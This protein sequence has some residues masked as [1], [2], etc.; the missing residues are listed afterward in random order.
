MAAWISSWFKFLQNF[1]KF[2]GS[3]LKRTGCREGRKIEINKKKMSTNISKVE[4]WQLENKALR[5]IR[6]QTSSSIPMWTSAR[7]LNQGRTWVLAIQ[8]KRAHYVVS[9]SISKYMVIS[10]LKAVQFLWK[11]FFAYIFLPGWISLGLRATLNLMV[12]EGNQYLHISWK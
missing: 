9:R 6:L 4:R 2:L 10:N 12:D 3:T 8:V 7:V 1:L 11:P 5:E